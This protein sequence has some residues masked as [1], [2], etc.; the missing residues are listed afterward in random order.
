[1]DLT[2]TVDSAAKT[3]ILLIAGF[4]PMLIAACILYISSDDTFETL[5]YSIS[6]LLGGALAAWIADKFFK[7]PLKEY[8]G[9]LNAPVMLFVIM[10]AVFWSIST[11]FILGSVALPASDLEGKFPRYYGNM[12]ALSALKVLGISWLT[13]VGEE[14]LYRFSILNL[15]RRKRRDPLMNAGAVLITAI[16]FMIPHLF[17]GKDTI[18]DLFLFGCIT[19]FILVRTHN[20]IYP[21]CFHVV[22]NLTNMLLYNKIMRSD[23]D[24]WLWVTLPLSVCFLGGMLF[25]SR[26]LEI[27]EED[28]PEEEEKPAEEPEP[29]EAESE[30]EDSGQPYQFAGYYYEEDDEDEDEDESDE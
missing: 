14:L 18:L 16:L 17:T 30:T 19:G 21:I 29:A 1:M 20:I 8:S 3:V 23:S 10:A 4:V 2:K 9:S 24:D 12:S 7:I 26:K 13:P 25:A 6:L 22:A 27:E 11:C 15:L 5:A 28:E